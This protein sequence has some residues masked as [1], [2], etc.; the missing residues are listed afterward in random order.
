[1]KNFNLLIFLLLY[2][3]NLIAA[4]NNNES[5]PK[6]DS[7][8]NET[9]ETVSV[10]QLQKDLGYNSN[11]FTKVID[12][13]IIERSSSNNAGLFAVLVRYID[14]EKKLQL[15]PLVFIE[16]N[17]KEH[18]VINLQNDELL[19]KNPRNTLNELARIDRMK[20]RKMFLPI[21]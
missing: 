9:M 13:V 17:N 3:C 20:L 16:H 2:Q 14:G 10:N 7:L 6:S 4:F 12:E 8:F 19:L 1:M 15:K 11:E 21:E 18:I 5:L